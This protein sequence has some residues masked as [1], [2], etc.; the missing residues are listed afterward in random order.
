MLHDADVRLDKIY[1]RITLRVV[2]FLFFAYV[3]AMIDRT[4]IG[5]AQLR[6]QTD[7]GF[8][9]AVYGLGAGVFFAGYVL[10][11]VPCNLV[12]QRFG[13]RK[14][15]MRIMFCWGI[16]SM[17][18]ALVHTSGQLYFVRF[19]LGAFEAG[20][21]PGV[22]FYLTRWFP[23]SRRARATSWLFVAAAF[24]G[25]L[26]GLLAGAIMQYFDGLVGLRSWQWLFVLE[27]AP[28]V[29]LSFGAL[30]C[31]SESPAEARWLSDTEK[32]LLQTDLQ[33]Q[34]SKESDANSQTVL[35]VLRSPTILG[36]AAIYF[37]L[38]CGIYAIGF[39]MP[40]MLQAAGEVSMLQT[41]LLSALP[42]IVGMLGVRLIA[43]SSDRRGERTFHFATC[44]TVCG[45]SLGLLPSF[46]DN[47]SATL[48]L[49]SL[50]LVGALGAFPVFW[51]LPHRYLNE[52]TAAAGL[53]VI[54]SIG[55]IGGFA[56]P[57]VI[58]W[59][60]NE[61]GKLDGALYS[62]AGVLIASAIVLL[63]VVTRQVD[64]NS[65]APTNIPT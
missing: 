39:W 45:I 49:L 12:F 21:L 42:Y 35:E 6:M 60:R 14:T 11:E 2:S 56:S 16:A 4:N 41:G 38:N 44:M 8:S 7:L 17:T 5:F 47:L 27:G 58:G 64:A 22:L 61:T 54:S 36:L 10:F 32:R 33:R 65:T 26:G 50:G 52:A 51:S 46:S 57:A 25:I 28:A 31:L 63:I 30:L 19:F 20:F 55:Q 18:M 9:S 24:S 59:V 37:V 23:A 53:A 34:A 13:A 40:I 15:F 1:R 29:L 62:L 3:V 43:S 48:V